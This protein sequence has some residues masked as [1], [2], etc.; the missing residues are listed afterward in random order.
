MNE[1]LDNKAFLMGALAA[2]GSVTRAFISTNPDQAALLSALN[3]QKQETLSHLL[4]QP[5][6]EQTLVAF[7]VAWDMVGHQEADPEVVPLHP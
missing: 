3:F 1:E 6:P 2:I 4:A 5:Y 7:H